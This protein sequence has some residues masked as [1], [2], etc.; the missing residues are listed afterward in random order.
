MKKPEENSRFKSKCPRKLDSLP[1][2]WCPLGA[3]RMKAV[4]SLV[5]EPSQEEEAGLPGCPHAV[6][7]QFSNYCWFKYESEHINGDGCS[8]QEIASLL[9]LTPETVKKTAQTALDK[10]KK[11]EFIL[12]LKKHHGSDPIVEDSTPEDVYIYSDTIVD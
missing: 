12:D 11:N 4:R 8:D 7:H 10:I 5:K 3:L 6:S 2:T 9:G 1:S